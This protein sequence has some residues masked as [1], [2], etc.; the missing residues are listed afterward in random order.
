MIK[1]FKSYKAKENLSAVKF[2]CNSINAKNI[3][4]SSLSKFDSGDN[5]VAIKSLSLDGGSFAGLYKKIVVKK[6]ASGNEKN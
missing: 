5:S 2:L 6:S 3:E 1:K 4:I